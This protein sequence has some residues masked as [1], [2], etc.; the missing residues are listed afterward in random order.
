[1]GILTH[2]I[3]DANVM[4]LNDGTAIVNSG[5][6]GD[7]IMWITPS[8]YLQPPLGL[9]LR[10]FVFAAAAGLALLYVRWIASSSFSI[11]TFF[12]FN[13]F[14]YA[15]LNATLVLMAVAV[16]LSAIHILIFQQP[17]LFAGVPGWHFMNSLMMTMYFA[18]VGLMTVVYLGLAIMIVLQWIAELLSRDRR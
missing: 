4:S 13:H 7:H 17:Q 2:R 9:R 15:A 11:D 14:E 8:G 12:D 1:M 16:W 6:D 3:D 10:R 18:V 5:L